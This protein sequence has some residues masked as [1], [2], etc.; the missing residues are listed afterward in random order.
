MKKEEIQQAKKTADQY[1]KE[2]EELKAKVMAGENAAL[3]RV[4]KAMNIDPESLKTQ[5]PK[6]EDIIRLDVNHPVYINGKEFFGTVEVPKSVAEV[7]Q[8]ALGDRRSRILRELTGTNYKIE[9]I[10]GGGFAG[11]KVGEIGMDGETISGG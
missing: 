5:E 1:E 9:S 3:D 10:A 8:Q 6:K 11:R 7:I 4:C 2:I